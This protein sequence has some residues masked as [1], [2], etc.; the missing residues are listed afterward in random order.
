MV[1]W[2]P[3]NRP[4]GLDAALRCRR[5]VDVQDRCNFGIRGPDRSSEESRVSELKKRVSAE[6]ESGYILRYLEN[7]TDACP[8]DNS[9]RLGMFN[10]ENP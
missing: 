10:P 9:S 6:E 4:S 7:R 5:G 1:V 8:Q 3:P 2:F